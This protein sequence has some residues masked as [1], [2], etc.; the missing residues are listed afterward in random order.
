MSC[1]N[2]NC[3]HCAFQQGIS[4]YFPYTDE[5][6]GVSR[7]EVRYRIDREVYQNI[8]EGHFRDAERAS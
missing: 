5:A 7:R 1:L 2:W 3:G 4:P 6:T 8:R